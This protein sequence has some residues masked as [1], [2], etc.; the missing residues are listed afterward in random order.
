[1][2]INYT[3]CKP[4]EIYVYNEDFINLINEDGWITTYID[5][6]GS[7]FVKTSPFCNYG[8]DIRLATEQEKVQLLE[9]I[10]L[11]QYVT[12]KEVVE[13]SNNYPIF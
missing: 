12:K 8:A 13:F 6:N 4:G 2:K 7:E 1:M 5:I 10:A 11:G 3:D 9:S